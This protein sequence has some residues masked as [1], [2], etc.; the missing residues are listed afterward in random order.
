MQI[1]KLLMVDKNL[2]TIRYST[3]PVKSPC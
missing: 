2:T 1:Q 3:Q